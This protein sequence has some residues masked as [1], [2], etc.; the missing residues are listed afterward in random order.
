MEHLQKR[1][2]DVEGH[3]SRDLELLKEWED[4]RRL[5]DDPREK[6]RCE[7]EIT[8]LQQD[9]EQ[10]ERELVEI[11]TKMTNPIFRALDEIGHWMESQG[12]TFETPAVSEIPPA[13]RVDEGLFQGLRWDSWEPTQNLAR[14]ILSADNATQQALLEYI[15]QRLQS[16]DEEVRWTTGMLV[17][18]L[19]EWEP[20]LIP[21]RFL[22]RMASDSSFSVRSTAAMCFLQLAR[23]APARV[24]LLLLARLASPHEDWYVTQPATAAFL[25]LVRTRR[26]AISVIHDWAGSDDHAERE[27]AADMLRR[28]ASIDPELVPSEIVQRLCSDPDANVQVNADL[29]LESL[30]KA[31]WPKL[32]E[33]S[34][35]IMNLWVRAVRDTVRVGHSADH[36]GAIAPWSQL[37]GARVASRLLPWIRHVRKTEASPC[38]VGPG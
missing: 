17:E 32:R 36:K 22:E 19:V 14:L 12:Y 27:H 28:M 38:S 6:R 15:A 7:M 3:I 24:P 4:K 30:Q 25:T 1:K 18:T 2:R 9:L 35:S 11:G 23:S 33:Y 13:L 20:S 26:A 16:E 34:P 8:Q 31:G 5:A 29:A 37:Q 21:A 10:R